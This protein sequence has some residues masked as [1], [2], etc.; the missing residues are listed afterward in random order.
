MR[1]DEILEKKKGVIERYGKWS[2]HN[3]H[4]GGGIYTIENADDGM[5]DAE[6]LRRVFQIVSDTARKPL[7][8]MK[9]LDLAC[10]E[11]LYATE[12]ALQG[13]AATGVEFR[14]QSV[15]KARFAKEVLGL[16][17]LE[18]VQDDVRNVTAKKYGS[19]DAVLCLGILYH[20]DVPDIFKFLENIAALCTDVLV[21]DTNISL[22]PWKR[23]RHAGKQYFGKYYREHRAGTSVE[24]KLKNLWASVDNDRSFWFTKRSLINLLKDIGFTSVYECNIPA[25]PN[26]PKDRATIVAIKG[27]RTDLIT[28]PKINL[29]PQGD[30]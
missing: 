15:E 22:F 25:E 7:A 10:L 16:E 29:V 20:I 28:S 5:G 6:K 8:E 11:G 1:P 24:A 4:L 2:A 17:K 3:I 30:H 19:F 26:K 23:I 9:V 18:F 13:A 12:F 27:K 21:V 14:Q